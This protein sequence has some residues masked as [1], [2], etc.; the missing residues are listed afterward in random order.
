LAVPVIVSKVS[1]STAQGGS[2]LKA[3]S[4]AQKLQ[5]RPLGRPSG[6]QKGVGD[7]STQGSKPYISRPSADRQVRGKASGEENGQVTLDKEAVYELVERAKQGDAEPFGE[8]FRMYHDNIFRFARFRLGGREAAEDAVAE[9]FTRAWSGLPRYRPTGAPFVSWLY[10][11]ARHVVADIGTAERRVEPR[12]EFADEAVES[13][14]STADRIV[15]DQAISR[16]PEKQRQ[17]IELKYLVG[18]TNEEVG[19]AL[20]KSPGAVNAQQ[21]R[22]LEA[23]K[24][25]MEK[26]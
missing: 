8:I 19:A 25:L 18:L 21:W 5:T 14:L 4:V 1:D 24:R 22:A 11:I 26:R 7:A 13:A 23:L 12:A 2:Y 10:G 6:A 3:V 17:V 20:G 15:L 9:T 16:L